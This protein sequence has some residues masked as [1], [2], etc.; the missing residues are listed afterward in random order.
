MPEHRAQ[1]A[2][3]RARRGGGGQPT[4][5]AL[6]PGH[7][8]AH[9]DLQRALHGGP[10]GHFIA[11][12]HLPFHLFV[13]EI[14]N[15]HQRRRTVPF[16]GHHYRFQP[17]GFAKSSQKTIVGLASSADRCPFGKNDGPGIDGK[18]NEHA[19]DR[20]GQSA[21]L[22]HRPDIHVL[23]EECDGSR[24]AQFISCLQSSIETLQPRGKT[25]LNVHNV[26]HKLRGKRAIEISAR[27]ANVRPLRSLTP[28]GRSVRAVGAATHRIDGAARIRWLFQD[29]SCPG[30]SRFPRH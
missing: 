8:L 29:V 17:G 27:E 20:E 22:D 13:T 14:E 24:K 10:I 4:H 9:A 7:L 11:P 30:A 28:V 6:Q 18:A 21:A 23:K 1:Q 19:H 15:R 12:A 26:R 3:E 16:A 2:D 5:V 25:P